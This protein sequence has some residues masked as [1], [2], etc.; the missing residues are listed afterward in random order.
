MRGPLILGALVGSIVC[1]QPLPGLHYLG[2]VG[3]IGPPFD[4]PKVVDLKIARVL[5]PD[6]D[7]AIQ[8]TDNAG[9]PWR[10][11]ISIGAGVGWTDAWEGDFDGNSHQ[12]LMFATAVP[13]NGRCVDGEMITFLM[14]DQRGRPVPWTI[15]TRLPRKGSQGKI[16]AILRNLNHDGR[17]RLIATQCEYSDPSHPEFFGEDRSVTGLFEAHDAHWNIVRAANATELADLLR[18]NYLS[19]HVHLLPVEPVSWPD[20]GNAEPKQRN[21]YIGKVLPA[22]EGCLGVHILFGPDGQI[23]RPVDDRCETLGKTRFTLSSGETC[24]GWPTIVID[25]DAGREIVSAE[26]PRIEAK[27]REISGLAA[28]VFGQ[29][30]P[31]RC[32]PT[33]LWLS[34]AR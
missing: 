20:L 19:K 24:F 2:E 11:D 15:S 22:D 29:S 5:P 17:V 7:F 13:S 14:F 4:T 30:D 26:S 25:R 33:M 18:L 28:T 8:G 21:V 16:P 23:R 31:A 6:A 3:H 32:S 34:D 12:D 9:R 1:A 10:A 27:L